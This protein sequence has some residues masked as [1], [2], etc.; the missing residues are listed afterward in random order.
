VLSGSA[1]PLS[2][3]NRQHSAFCWFY[4]SD[5][6]DPL[7]VLDPK[8]TFLP[9]YNTGKTALR[10]NEPNQIRDFLLE[11]DQG[12]TSAARKRNRKLSG[13]RITVEPD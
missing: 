3:D 10:A 12:H 9:K 13:N 4:L 1:R 8:K 7:E 6:W 2:G 11:T 5:E